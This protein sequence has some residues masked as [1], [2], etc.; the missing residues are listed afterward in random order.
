ME[1]KDGKVI[2]EYFMNSLVNQTKANIVIIWSVNNKMQNKKFD[3]NKF[4]TSNN[5]LLWN[6]TLYDSI[7]SLLNI[8]FQIPS[9][10]VRTNNKPNFVFFNDRIANNETVGQE[11]ADD[12]N[13]MFIG[14]PKVPFGKSFHK[15]ST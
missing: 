5:M 13:V 3:K 11:C 4:D 6:G 7:T 1:S 9:K 14:K 8:G 10:H 2:V 15:K 12:G